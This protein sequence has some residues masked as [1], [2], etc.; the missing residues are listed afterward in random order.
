MTV[1]LLIIRAIPLLIMLTVAVSLLFGLMNKPTKPKGRMIG[2]PIAMFDIPELGKP[3]SHFSPKAWEGRV[4]LINIFASWCESCQAEHGVLHALSQTGKLPIYGIAWKD[5]EQN[6][7]QWLSAYGNPYKAVGFDN[8]GRTTLPFS[9][10]GIPETFLVDKQ[11]VVRFHYNA[12]LTDDV[13]TT[14]I[15]PLAEELNRDERMGR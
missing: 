4:A 6:I 9:M 2:K 13:I 12:A 8:K 3:G 14:E 11:G 10:T 15:L 5:K 1:R 7:H